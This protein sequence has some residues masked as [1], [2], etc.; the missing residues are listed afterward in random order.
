MSIIQ[1]VKIPTGK[2]LVKQTKKGVTYVDYEYD[3]TY[4]KDTK[5]T[6]PKR[7]TIGKLCAEDPSMMWPNQNYLKFFPNTELPETIARSRRSSCLRIGSYLVIRKLLENIGIPD[8]LEHFFND[9]DKGLFLDLM[10]YT[11]ITEDNAGQYYPDYAFNHPLFTKEMTLYSDTKVSD[12]LRG[13][14][15]DQRIGFLNEWNEQRD[16]RETIYI[17]YDSTNKNCQ[18]GEV[19]FAEYGYAKDD[20]SKPII[21]YSV[22]YDTDNRE[23]LFYEEYPGSINDVSQLRLMVT[24][25]KGYGYK[26]IGFILD[27]GYYDRKNFTYMDECGYSFVIMV[28]GMKALVKDL[29]LEKKGS[30]EKKRSCYIREHGVAGVTIKRKMYETDEKERYF[31]LYYSLSRENR[32]R[33]EL[34]E[35]L[36]KMS[37]A[38][39]KQEGREYQFSKSYEDYYHLFYQEEK[40][41]VKVLSEEGEQE[42]QEKE[43][44]KQVIFLFGCER[45]DVVEAETDLQGYFSIVTSERMTA[46]EAIGLYNNRDVSEKLFRADKSFLGNHSYRVCSNEAVSAKMFIEFVALIIRNR[47]Y[48]ALQDEMKVLGTKPNYMTVPAALRELEK[49]EMVRLTDNIY[50]LDHA[51][52]KTQKTILRAFGMDEIYVEYR[53][54][55]L[56]AELKRIAENA[57]KKG[58]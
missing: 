14:T 21:N 2:K 57:M 43:I 30:F 5:Y 49:I 26:H 8:I 20:S 3:R 56:Q 55:Q 31:H 34:E 51:V 40:E 46:A 27:R 29:I 42:E 54:G 6:R 13:V 23:P 7:S 44:I 16:H 22:A 41:K 38:L 9:R 37:E 53:A 47:F 45:E 24:K 48:T 25:A 18:A 1:E 32:E 36:K 52:T 15:E 11:I 4:D 17:S 50:H 28:K 58:A 39:K 33:M 35:K 10:I 19:D 12:F